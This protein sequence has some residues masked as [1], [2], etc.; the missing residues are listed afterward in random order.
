MNG[1]PY[2][3]PYFTVHIIDEFFVVG[4]VAPIMD[5]IYV[6]L[7]FM[8]SVRAAGFRVAFQGD[9]GLLVLEEK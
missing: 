3:I 8:R 5:N 2:A 6:A 9:N 7:D 4:S 1:D